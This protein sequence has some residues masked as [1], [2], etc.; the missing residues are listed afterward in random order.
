MGFFKRCRKKVCNE[1]DEESTWSSRGFRI[2]NF[3]LHGQSISVAN[4]QG[5]GSFFSR[6]AGAI[7]ARSLGGVCQYIL[8]RA[9]DAR[10]WDLSLA[11]SH[12][13]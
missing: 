1:L 8:L 11:A 5:Q 2:S 12:R 3:H 9:G 7:R 4:L 13:A 6:A 10:A